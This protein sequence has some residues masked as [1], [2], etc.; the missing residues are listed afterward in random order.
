[1]QC[2]ED[3]PGHDVPPAFADEYGFAFRRAP[4]VEVPL[5]ACEHGPDPDYELRRTYRPSWRVLVLA[6]LCEQARKR[7]W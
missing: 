2:L 7:G 3:P 1:M 5:N 4:F 6:W